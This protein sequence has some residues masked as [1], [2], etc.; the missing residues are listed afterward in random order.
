MSFSHGQEIENQ[1]KEGYAL[2]SGRESVRKSKIE[3]GVG[4]WKGTNWERI[5]NNASRDD[6]K[7]LGNIGENAI[8]NTKSSLFFLC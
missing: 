1:Q 3:K 2:P 7:Q 8:A 5:S 6:N 4:Y